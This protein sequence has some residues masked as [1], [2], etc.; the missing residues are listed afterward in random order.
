MVITTGDRAAETELRQPCGEDLDLALR[1]RLAQAQRR[2]KPLI[3]TSAEAS[4][5]LGGGQLVGTVTKLAK[6]G[7]QVSASYRLGHV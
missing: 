3:S 2:P 7:T 5:S 1:L 6:G 4:Y